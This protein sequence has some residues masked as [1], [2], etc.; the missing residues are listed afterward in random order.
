MDLKRTNTPEQ[1]D[2][3]ARQMVQATAAGFYRSTY[4]ER[5]Q[6][7]A[8]ISPTDFAPKWMVKVSADAVD[9]IKPADPKRAQRPGERPA[10]S[11]HVVMPAPVKPGGPSTYSGTAP[12][13]DQA[14]I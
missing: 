2:A 10:S 9:M 5:G 4:I 13:G 12:T 11:V 6:T 14:V 3:P 7:F 8:L 1:H